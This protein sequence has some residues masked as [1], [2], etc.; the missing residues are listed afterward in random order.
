[1]INTILS[2]TVIVSLC[3]YLYTVLRPKFKTIVN[4]WFCQTNQWVPWL[5]RNS[6]TCKKCDQ[7]NG[8]D[9]NGDYNKFIAPQRIESLNMN[10]PTAKKSMFTTFPSANG[11]CDD[12]NQRQA[13][14]IERLN[15]FEAVDERKYFE[16]YETVKLKLNQRYPLC[17][18]C[19]EFTAQKLQSVNGKYL[20]KPKNAAKGFPKA[21]SLFS[22]PNVSKKTTVFPSS[23]HA[24]ARMSEVSS[25]KTPSFIR[26]SKAPSVASGVSYKTT[27]SQCPVFNEED[28]YA[29]EITLKREPNHRHD[30]RRKFYFASGKVTVACN[31][32]TF[33]ISAIL[34]IAFFDSSQISVDA[35]ILTMEQ[36]LPIDALNTL[37]RCSHYAPIIGAIVSAIFYYGFG[38]SNTRVTFLDLLASISWP[39]FSIFCIFDAERNPDFNL[40][41]MMLAAYLFCLSSMILFIPKKRKHRKRANTVY[42]AFSVAST[43]ASQCSSR[44]SHLT[45]ASRLQNLSNLSNISQT[46]PELPEVE[47]WVRNVE[48]HQTVTKLH[49]LRI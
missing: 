43:P 6:F 39:I 4:C 8:F 20:P 28:E 27:R 30:R 46:D 18:R 42:S 10:K 2:G 34:F 1:M 29:E 14:I 41:I 48:E 49:D 33:I 38:K 7:Y 16:E 25:V 3:F 11:L 23:Y 35:R 36:Y 21:S 15:K 5:N 31:F 22:N 9:E 37:H 12:C 17:D 44:I 47:S 32:V 13:I 19:Q 45:T 40:V 26:V 24:S